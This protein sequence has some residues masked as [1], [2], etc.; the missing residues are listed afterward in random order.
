[1]P[2]KLEA[3]LLL[4]LVPKIFHSCGLCDSFIFFF[5]K[6]DKAYCYGLNFV[7]PKFTL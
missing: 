1:M 4:F 3:V 6:E 7:S 5:R 2:W